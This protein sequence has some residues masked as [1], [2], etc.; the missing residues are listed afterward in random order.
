MKEH[1]LLPG[2][3]FADYSPTMITTVL[4]SCV[5][6]CLWDPYLNI[7]GINHYLLPFWNGEGLASPRYGNVAFEKLM[8][9]M[10]RLG[11]NL[12]DV[13]AKVFGGA[14]VLEIVSQNM[15]V[16]ERNITLAKEMLNEFRIPII[17]SDV[18]GTVGRKLKFNSQ[19]GVVFIKRLQ[20]KT[21]VQLYS[22]N[23]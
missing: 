19:T 23:N 3:I 20:K 12:Q 10:Q 5:S 18:G 17:S 6:I 22:D 1:Y 2:D 14:A 8:E 13:K 7:G 9:K 4:G 16:G 21:F 11:S 15:S